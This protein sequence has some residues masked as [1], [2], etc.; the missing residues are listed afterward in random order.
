MF[1]IKSFILIPTHVYLPIVIHREHV[2]ELGL[3]LSKRKEAKPLRAK[4]RLRR[5]RSETP[6]RRQKCSLSPFVTQWLS[7]V[8]P[9]DLT[10]LGPK[11]KIA[12]PQPGKGRYHLPPFAASDSRHNLCPGTTLSREAAGRV[13]LWALAHPGKGCCYLPPSA[14]SDSRHNLSFS[15]TVRCEAPGRVCGRPLGR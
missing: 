10:A 3:F 11:R 15:T 1:L 13:C 9:G 6:L 14:A 8:L 4:S 5:L 2:V 12:P 7:W